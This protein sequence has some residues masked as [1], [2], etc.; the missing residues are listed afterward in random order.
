MSGENFSR[1]Y[2]SVAPSHDF[3]QDQRQVLAFLYISKAPV[4]TD[5]V[6]SEPLLLELVGVMDVLRELAR[7]RFVRLYADGWALTPVTR[8]LLELGSDVSSAL[9]AHGLEGVRHVR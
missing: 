6:L 1:M 7:N 8:L 3:T 2:Q 5:N 4:P 9:S